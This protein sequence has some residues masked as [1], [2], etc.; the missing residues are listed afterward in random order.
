MAEKRKKGAPKGNQN[1]RKNI[2][3]SKILSQTERR[4]LNVAIDVEGIDEEIALLRHEIKRAI[5]GGDE[6]NLL[7]MVKA[8]GA[9]EKL[10]RA[11]YR[12]T[13]TRKNGLTEGIKNIIKDYLVPLGVNIG[14]A[15]ITRKIT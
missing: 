8:A 6:R 4:D 7:L 2:Y 15:V 10:F 14:G 1:A 5:S 9:M 11:R 3:Y 13:N 12:V